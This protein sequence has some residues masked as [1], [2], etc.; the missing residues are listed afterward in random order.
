MRFN[1]SQEKLE[2]RISEASQR[3]CGHNPPERLATIRVDGRRR[4]LASASTGLFGPSR[5]LAK[6]AP[7]SSSAP[8]PLLV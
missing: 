4:I 5:S 7:T 1:S 6:V 8:P 2:A 3:G